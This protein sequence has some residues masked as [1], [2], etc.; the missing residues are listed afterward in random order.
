MHYGW[1]GSGFVM[2]DREASEVLWQHRGVEEVTW[3]LEDTMQAAYPFLFR[4]K[5]T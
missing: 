1:S 4:D 2:Q 5:C 3:E